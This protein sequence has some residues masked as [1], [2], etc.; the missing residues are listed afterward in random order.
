[1]PEIPRYS[2]MPMDLPTSA[3]E[4][5]MVKPFPR[6]LDTVQTP[7]PPSLTS[8]QWSKHNVVFKAVSE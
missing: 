4:G 1:M 3:A 5:L 6:P 2:F 8:E 7:A